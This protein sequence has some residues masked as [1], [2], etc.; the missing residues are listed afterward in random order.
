M[1]EATRR[2]S[3]SGIESN[4]LVGVAATLSTN[5]RISLVVFSRGTPARW[6]RVSSTDNSARRMNMVEDRASD[7]SGLSKLTRRSG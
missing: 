5:L 7:G 4:P 2:L 6:R 1:T 3:P